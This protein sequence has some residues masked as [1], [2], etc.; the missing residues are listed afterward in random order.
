MHLRRLI[1]VKIAV[2][3]D[4]KILVLL[5][6]LKSLDPSPYLFKH[7]HAGMTKR[8]SVMA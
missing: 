8:N 1:G 6:D 7:G 5:L 3:L 2:E 4:D